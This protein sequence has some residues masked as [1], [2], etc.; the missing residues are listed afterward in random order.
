MLLENVLADFVELVFNREGNNALLT[1]TA[2]L[3]VHNDNYFV[4]L[5]RALKAQ[6]PQTLV[7]LGREFFEPL[8]ADYIHDYPSHSPQLKDYGAYFPEFLLR[9]ENMKDLAYVADIARLEWICHQ[10]PIT[11]AAFTLD[12]ALLQLKETDYDKLHVELNPA[13][14]LMS[15]Q[16]PLSK[17][18]AYCKS[19]TESL[20][21]ISIDPC[22][23]LIMKTIH[24]VSFFSLSDAEYLFLNDLANNVSLSTALTHALQKDDTFQLDEIL[25][26]WIATKVIQRI[27]L[28]Q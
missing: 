16:Y 17:L 7:L 24:G 5:T 4:T 3:P 11:D 15:S 23:L 28:D 2:L 22:H 9:H 8:C 20:F 1:S 12:D 10:L 19:P 6:Y 18:M 13:I 27:Y 21:E 14:Q 25:S 26:N